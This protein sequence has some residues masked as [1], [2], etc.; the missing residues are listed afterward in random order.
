MSALWRTSLVIA[1]ASGMTLGC[2][3]ASTDDQAGATV[4]ETAAEDTATTADLESA[5]SDIQA[6]ADAWEAALVAGDVEALV[7]MNTEDAIVMGPGMPPAR[8]TDELRA[9]YESMVS[10]VDF[11]EFSIDIER[12]EVAESGDIAWGVGTSTARVTLPDGGTAE[13][14]DRFAVAFENVDGEW[15]VAADVWNTVEAPAAE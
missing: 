4:E 12:L 14:E 11:Q 9:T 13:T 8:G 2:E 10:G 1:L 15:L 7:A 6:A 5:R 3:A